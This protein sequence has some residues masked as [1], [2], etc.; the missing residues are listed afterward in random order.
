MSEFVDEYETGRCWD[1]LG[2]LFAFDCGI[3][4]GTIKF[5]DGVSEWEGNFTRSQA[6]AIEKIWERA[7][8]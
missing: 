4:S 2:E 7:F 5:L 6:E 8:G 3:D 1:M